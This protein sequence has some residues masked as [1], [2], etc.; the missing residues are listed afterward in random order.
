MNGLCLVDFNFP[1]V[2]PFLEDVE[3][4]LKLLRGDDWISMDRKQPGVIRKSGDVSKFC[5]G[6]VGSED[7]IEQ[8]SKDTSLWNTR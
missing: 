5:C 1:C 3:V 4:V 8:G 6:Q 2:D 7:R